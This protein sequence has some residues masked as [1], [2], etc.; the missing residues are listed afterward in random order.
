[1]DSGPPLNLSTTI[2]VQDISATQ[3]G[4]E[5]VP[6]AVV[7]FSGELVDEAQVIEI[8]KLKEVR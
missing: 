4:D 6:Y 8:Y 7:E 3:Q 1:M 5:D 2:K